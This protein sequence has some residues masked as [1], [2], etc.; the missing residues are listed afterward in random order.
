[1]KSLTRV[2]SVHTTPAR[3]AS[4]L[5]SG[6]SPFVLVPPLQHRSYLSPPILAIQR[7]GFLIRL[8]YYSGQ[9]ASC[10]PTKLEATVYLCGYSDQDKPLN[11]VLT[12]VAGSDIPLSSI[13]WNKPVKTL[14]SRKAPRGQKK[15]LMDAR[16]EG[17]TTLHLEFFCAFWSIASSMPSTPPGK[18]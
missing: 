15:A 2:D 13:P 9:M 4:S 1:M 10:G 11:L 3:T 14:T 16:P 8:L 7:T 18:N 17:L 6:H 12:K 5:F